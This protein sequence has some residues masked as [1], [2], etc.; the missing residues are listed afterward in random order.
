MFPSIKEVKTSLYHTILI[1]M[2]GFV[3]K[4]QLVPYDFYECVWQLSIVADATL[5]ETRSNLK[6]PRLRLFAFA[7]LS[8]PRLTL[9]QELD[10]DWIGLRKFLNWN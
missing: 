4:D 9:G 10:K 1:D 3:F 8:K 2:Y 5:K 6:Q 7:T